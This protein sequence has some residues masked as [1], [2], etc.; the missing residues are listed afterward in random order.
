MKKQFM[1][2]IHANKLKDAPK[3]GCLEGCILV[4]GKKRYLNKGTVKKSL[5]KLIKPQ[6]Q[7]FKLEQYEGKNPTLFIN[8]W[9]GYQ[10]PQDAIPR[11]NLWQRIKAIFHRP[12]R[13]K[14]SLEPVETL[15]SEL[16][17]LPDDYDMR[18]ISDEHY[19]LILNEIHKKYVQSVY[20]SNPIKNKSKKILKK[21]K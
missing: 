9:N 20:N 11:S 12:K 1:L 18:H 21:N 7:T 4:V 10:R 17:Q 6:E 14:E 19:D 13:S 2:Q 8:D 3:S 5:W 15:N 16:L